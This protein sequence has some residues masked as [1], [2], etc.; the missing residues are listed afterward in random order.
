M[1]PLAHEQSAHPYC[2]GQEDTTAPSCEEGFSSGMDPAPS[3]VADLFARGNYATLARSG[4]RTDWRTYASMGLIGKTGEAIAGLSQFSHEEAAFYAAVA[5][6]IGGQEDDR[7]AGL[8]EPL[9]H[10]HAQNLLELV[11]KPRIEVLAQLPSGRAGCSDLLS[12]ARHDPRFA[13]HNISFHPED[14]PCRPHANIHEFYHR[15]QPPDYY[16]CAMVEWHLIPPNLQELPCP[17]L[18]QTADYDLHIQAVHPWLE[19][20]DEL[21]VTDPSEWDDVTRLAAVPVSTFPKSFV[22]PAGI[23]PLQHTKRE[24]DVYLSGSVFHPYHLDKGEL[25][26]QL[27]GI[28]WLSVQLSNGFKGPEAYYQSL[29]NAKLSITYVRHSQAL[30]TRGLE[31]LAM[32]CATIV[33]RGNVLTLFVGEEEGVL[34]YDLA[35]QDLAQ[36]V[37][38]VVEHWPEFQNRAV[39]GGKRIREEFTGPRVASQYLRFLTF[40]AARPRGPR[41][42][43]TT[44]RVQKRMVLEKGWLPSHDFLTSPVLRAIAIRNQEQ[45]QSVLQS[46]PASSHPFIDAAR[47][48]VLV[49]YHRV[50]AGEEASDEWL[51]AVRGLYTRCQDTFPRS[52]VTR[53]NHIRVMLHFGPASVVSK[54]LELLEE[55]L[56][57]PEEHWQVDV[58]EDVFPWDFFPHFFN[59]RCYFDQITEHLAQNTDVAP[60]LKRLILASLYSYRAFFPVSNGCYLRS[61][62]DYRRAMELD[63]AFPYYTLWY[64]GQLMDRALPE[65][66]ARARSILTR[67]VQGCV[68]LLE[69]IRLLQKL[70]EQQTEQMQQLEVRMATLLGQGAGEEASR[71]RRQIEYLRR[72]WR[73][74]D[75]HDI[76]PQGRIQIEQLESTTLPFQPH[77]NLPTSDGSNPP[78]PPIASQI[79]ILHADLVAQLKVKQQEIDHLLFRIQAMEESKFWLARKV[80][81]RFK[82]WLRLTNEGNHTVG[83]GAWKDLSG[84]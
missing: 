84:K 33:Q 47:E 3:S 62:D 68:P 27:L 77:P 22:L 7:V 37:Q 6:W 29:A 58:M 16:I 69:T 26:G 81:F 12:G 13:V 64:S 60:I 2:F 31:S 45:L 67:L 65:D 14:L 79:S 17:L 8:L 41:A 32:G 83:A 56:A 75:F 25:V 43:H 48:S 1:S 42:R 9:R 21:V 15:E 11:R 50:K 46:T 80:W 4:P 34:E 59:Y 49:H 44:P 36:R 40:L 18:G 23:P 54:G 71:L 39:Q 28:P 74:D 78:A 24:V 35:S 53:F 66:Y 55:T 70:H 52:L 82:R 51:T 61:L 30:P 63:P 19:L 10:E 57:Y 76:L 72:I 20:F 5:L 73:L 38:Q